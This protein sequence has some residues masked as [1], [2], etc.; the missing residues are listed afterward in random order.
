MRKFEEMLEKEVEADDHEP[1][2]FPTL[3]PEANINKEKEHVKGFSPELFWVTEAGGSKLA[4]KYYLRPTGESQI[5]PMFGLWIR[6]HKDLPYKRYQ[7]RMTVFRFEPT[8]RPYLRGREFNFF[9]CHD[10]FKDHKSAL[11]QVERD[12][13]YSKK[14]MYDQLGIP[15][16][17]LQR[18]QW[19]KF[20]GAEN[21]FGAESFTPDGRVN[22][23]ASTHDLGQKFAKTYGIK[24][25]DEKEKEEFGW[26]TCYGPGLVRIMA[27][28]I[29]VHGD[30]RGLVLPFSV[31]PVQIIIVPITFEKGKKKVFAECQK[32]EAELKEAGYRVKFDE[33]DNSP[34]WKFNQWEMLGVPIRLEI[35]PKEV[36]EKKVT[37]AR[38]DT[39]EKEM[40]SVND[41]KK[42]IEF[43]SVDILKT[44]KKK[45]DAYFD[46]HI[47][48]A[49][50]LA[51]VR[52]ILMKNPGIIKAPWCSINI[53]GENCS[54][55][56]RKET[57][58]GKVRGVLFN[59]QEKVSGKCIICGK[60]ANHLVYIAKSH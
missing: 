50:T 53:D 8:T 49:R 45:A 14:V 3:V 47:F 46:N 6:S 41:L 31:A 22:T 33:T 32:I 52:D 48:E 2:L 36:D 18:P 43:L 38:R 12:M 7:S 40:I 60:K 23:I 39:R 27:G 42:K 9:E 54:D 11:K 34:G 30:D 13:V 51:E 44:L 16:L 37:V 5:Y 17:F 1:F 4:E 59:K 20:A 21:T 57:V 24:F 35:G 58:G 29:A 55:I 26:Q 15:F 19:D 28:L 25:R 56:L 10:V